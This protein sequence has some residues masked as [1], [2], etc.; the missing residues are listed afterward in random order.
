MHKINPLILF[1][2]ADVLVNLSAGWFGAATILPAF[3]EKPAILNL[4]ILITDL[5][6]GTVCFVTAYR[7]RKR[8]GKNNGFS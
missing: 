7:L 2:I 6:F 8:G 3:S 1:T 4:P 5:I